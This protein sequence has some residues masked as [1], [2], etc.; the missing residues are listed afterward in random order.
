MEV[1]PGYKQTE[2]GVIP[3]DWATY[4][5]SEISDRIMVGIVI[6]PTQYYVPDGVPAFRSANIREDGITDSDLVFISEASNALLAKSQTQAG[7]ILTVRTGYPGTSAVVRNA[8]A[9]CNCIDILIT[10]PSK[11]VDSDFLAIWINSSFGKEQVLRNQGGLA[12]KHFNVGDMRNLVVAL[13]PLHEQR[14]IAGALSDA[15][16][17]IESLEQLVAKKRQIKHGAMQELLTGRR[18]LPGFTGKWG[19]CRFDRLFTALRN[20]SNSRSELSEEGDVAYVHYGDIHTHPSAFLNPI[21]LRTFIARDKVRTI[22]RII[23]GDL[24]MADASE[25]TTAIGKA[26]EI[27]G[28][29]GREAVAGLHTMAL[30]GNTDLEDGYKGYIQF[31]PEVRAALVRLATG[32]SVYGITKAGVKAIEVK[33]PKPTEQSAIASILSDMDA[34]IAGLEAKLMKARQ[35]KQGMMQELLTGRIRLAT[36]TTQL[37]S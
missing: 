36:S 37:S 21:A 28:L 32:V 9:G 5:C 27:T 15:D 17:L 30:R 14:A 20:A 24:L 19:T 31:L 16:A 26:V 25:D 34:E 6:R 3:V 22:P 11:K 2:V 10:R 7:D 18:R 12:Q 29:N 35:V 8:Q 13:P 4:P 33:I 23:D 1:K